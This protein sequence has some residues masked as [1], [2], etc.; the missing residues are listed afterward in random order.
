MIKSLFSTINLK[1][2]CTLLLPKITIFSQHLPPESGL[3]MCQ[4]VSF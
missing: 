2:T 4:F 1:A 3:C